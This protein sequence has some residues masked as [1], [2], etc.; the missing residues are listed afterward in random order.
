VRPPAGSLSFAEGL[1]LI[2]LTVAMGLLLM[3]TAGL[4]GML[5]PARGA[6]VAEPEAADMQQ[7]LRVAADTLY[8]SLL[9]SGAG[10]R[11]PGVYAF[12]PVLPFRAGQ[13]RGDPP[14]TFAADRITIISVPPNAAS[15]NLA[16]DL[17]P[18]ATA[19]TV[20]PEAGCPGGVALCRFAAG[21]TVLVYD[22]GGRFDTFSLAAVD[23]GLAVLQ[24][25]SRSGPS[26]AETFGTGS[27]IGE[28]RVDVY[29]LKTDPLTKISQL[30][31]ADGSAHADVPV[32]DHLVGLAFEYYGEPRA[33]TL[34]RPVSDPVGPWTTYGP[35][36]P[37]MDVAWTAY[38][39]GENCIFQID[40]A[41]TAQVPRLADLSA[42]LAL[43][44]LTPAQLTDGPWCPDAFSANRWDADLLRVRTVV[45]TVRVEAALAALR[46]P[47]GRLFANGGLSKAP[48]RWMPDIER[49]FVVSPRNLNVAR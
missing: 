28:A 21:E 35:R 25:D 22:E 39:A 18:G 49:Q 33:P 3:L 44:K 13:S 32:V 15:S 36:P 11:Q 6:S 17:L 31:H 48:N 2:E 46:G 23:D 26:S 37:P 45:V 16:G 12:A 41:G 34:I 1:S 19:V 47:A 30:M 42:A 27:P 43:V 40:G 24:A 20:A 4:F 38:P 7:R 29:Y 5:A 10:S 14:G 9:A 8:R